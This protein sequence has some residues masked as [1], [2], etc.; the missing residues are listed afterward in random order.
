VSSIKLVDIGMKRWVNTS[1]FYK[2][3][4]QDT[5]EHPSEQCH[6]NESLHSTDCISYGVCKE[7]I[8]HWKPCQM[9]SGRIHGNFLKV[10]LR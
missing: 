7:S 1:M 5:D 2:D 10:L 6:E 9:P 8:I 4:S 3:Y